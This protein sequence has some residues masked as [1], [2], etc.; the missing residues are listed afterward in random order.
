MYLFNLSEARASIL[1]I[2]SYYGMKKAQGYLESILIFKGCWRKE[3]EDFTPNF[4]DYLP[5]FPGPPSF[6]QNFLE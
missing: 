4:F 3:V 2:C 5:C 1:P 6:A